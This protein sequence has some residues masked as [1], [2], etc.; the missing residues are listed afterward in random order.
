[1]AG[2]P[3]GVGAYATDV[4]VQDKA[5]GNASKVQVW[6][7]GSKKL[8]DVMTCADSPKLALWCFF[9]VHDCNR[10]SKDLIV[11]TLAF[12]FPSH[13]SHNTDHTLLST[14]I[15]RPSWTLLEGQGILHCMRLPKCITFEWIAGYRF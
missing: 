4:R 13:A 1:M 2:Q 5:V 6:H 15:H 11:A 12:F 3:N 9:Y 14:D 8:K 10:L 7:L